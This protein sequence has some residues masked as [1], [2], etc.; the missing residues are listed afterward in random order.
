MV[1]K[2]PNMV[3]SQSRITTRSPRNDTEMQGMSFVSQA[4]FVAKKA[5]GEIIGTYQ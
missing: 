5:A 4:T 3:I 1:S 2:D